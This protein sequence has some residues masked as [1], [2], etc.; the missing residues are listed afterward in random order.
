[1]CTRYL[2]GLAIILP[3]DRDGAVGRRAGR[4]VANECS[5]GGQTDGIA[6]GPNR[7]IHHQDIDHAAVIASRRDD[8][9]KIPEGT[10]KQNRYR[11]LRSRQEACAAQF[12]VLGFARRQPSG[13]RLASPGEQF[14]QTRSVAP[15][16]NP[17]TACRG[18]TRDPAGE[19]LRPLDG[20]SNRL[21]W[22]DTHQFSLITSL[23]LRLQSA[24]YV[25]M[26]TRE[27]MKRHELSM[28]R[29]C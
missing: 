14:A 16:R 4:N 11:E 21:S 19:R 24:R 8:W 25:S 1:M 17:P 20:S 22:Q 3:H 9:N 6:Y 27:E 29:K 23:P 26:L 5:P 12:C 10:Q 2:G 18:G 28:F 7:P 13:C 15:A